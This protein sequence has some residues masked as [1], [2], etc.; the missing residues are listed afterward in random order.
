MLLRF[1]NNFFIKLMP[2]LL[3]INLSAG[4]TKVVADNNDHVLKCPSNYSFPA[5]SLLLNDVSPAAQSTRT[6]EITRWKS[7]SLFH[8]IYAKLIV[9]FNFFVL[10]IRNIWSELS[11]SGIADSL[12]FFQVRIVIFRCS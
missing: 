4:I 12:L 6:V 11:I 2:S 10:C 8:F 7:C 3:L 5:R 9:N 1:C